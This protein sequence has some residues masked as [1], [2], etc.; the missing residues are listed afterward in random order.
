MACYY[1]HIQKR[2]KPCYS[3]RCFNEQ[4]RCKW[5]S[6]Q[7]SILYRSGLEKPPDYL[8]TL[9]CPEF[10]RGD[11]AT[12]VFNHFCKLLSKHLP[13]GTE[14][15]QYWFFDPYVPGFYPHIHMLVRC[16]AVLTSEMCETAW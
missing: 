2:G 4:C 8:I 14:F 15:A 3:R 12:N 1:D 5:A 7:H 16:S 11:G 13:K 6:K 9:V 10:W